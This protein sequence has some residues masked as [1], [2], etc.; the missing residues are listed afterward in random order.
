MLPF[1]STFDSQRDVP[2][3]VG[4]HLNL[5]VPWNRWYVSSNLIPCTPLEAK[6]SGAS[7]LFKE[8]TPVGN[9]RTKTTCSCSKANLSLSSRRV[10]TAGQPAFT[11][12]SRKKSHLPSLDHLTCSGVSM[13]GGVA[14]GPGLVGLWG[15]CSDLVDQ[16]RNHVFQN[17]FREFHLL[18]GLL[19]LIC[20][21]GKHFNFRVHFSNS[22]GRDLCLLRTNRQTTVEVGG[23]RNTCVLLQCFFAWDE[24]Q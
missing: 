15:S 20:N 18:G 7:S 12:Q 5:N 4:T 22:P 17:E 1:D 14:V 2:P 10:V 11:P 19:F 21:Y 3:H 8:H 16:L 9:A 6:A 13:F 23:S 24:A